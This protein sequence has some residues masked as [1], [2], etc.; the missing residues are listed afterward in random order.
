VRVQRDP[1]SRPE[2]NQRE[3]GYQV[4]LCKLRREVE[5]EREAVALGQLIEGGGK[6]GRGQELPYGFVRDLHHSPVRTGLRMR[7]ILRLL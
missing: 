6:R 4:K 3:D 1:V 5:G 2:I 7:G